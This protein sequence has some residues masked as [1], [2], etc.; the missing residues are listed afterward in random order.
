MSIHVALN[1]VTHYRYDRPVTLGPQVVRL[2][3]APH[4]RTPVL[5][6]S[7]R[8]A[9]AKHFVNWQ[10]DPQSNYLARLVFPEKTRELRDR[11]RPGRRDVGDQPVRLL[12][13]AARREVSR[14]SYERLRSCTSW[15]RTCAKA[16][17]TPLLQ[18][19]TSTRSRA[20][21]RRRSISS[22]SSTA[23]LS[24]RHR[25]TSSAWSPACRR[26]RRRWRAASGSCRDSG[27]LLVQLLRH[28][29]LAARFVS[30]Y[31]IQLKPDVKSLDGPSGTEVDFTDLHAWCEVY[32]PGAGWIGLDPT[33]GLLAG[34]GHIPLACTPEPS[35]RRADH[36][37]SSTKCEVEFAHHDEASTRMLGSAARHQALH[38]RAVGAR[39][40]RSATRVDADLA[41]RRRAPDHGRR[42]DL[43]LGRR[44]RRRRVEHRGAWARTSAACG[45]VCCAAEGER[46][47]RRACCISARASGIR[48]SSC[49]AGRSTCFWRK[50]GEPV[51]ENPAL[52]AD[53]ARRLR[54]R[55]RRRRRASC[56][57]LAAAARRS[58][59]SIVFPAFEDT[60][61]YLWRERRLPANV[62][63]FDARL[64]DPLERERLRKVFDAGPRQGRRPCAAGERRHDERAGR[65][66]RGSCAASA[67][68]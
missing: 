31:L 22:S 51:W 26:R 49:R 57:A 61:Y 45:R 66:G 10:Q 23:Q 6:Y 24:Q 56:A 35:Q 27:W 33:S 46:T 48:A 43:R 4:A 16:P 58:I 44:P 65:A 47:R 52:F 3:P 60:W 64:D 67:A 17:L 36:R 41:A 39:S 12:P 55:R 53:E 9:P 18:G 19:A 50:D 7:L 8:V 32:L 14:S 20:S 38:R 62:D 1:H 2:R 5:A 11:G 28:L 40:T 54:R 37:R 68:T 29:G 25:A 63:P 30:G 21:R 42:A 13:R 59:R 34:E 15:R